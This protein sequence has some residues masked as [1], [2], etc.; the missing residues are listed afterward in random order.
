M[1]V[2]G[3]TMP[4]H[5]GTKEED[6]FIAIHDLV[7]VDYD[8]LHKYV[9]VHED[10]SPFHKNT[11]M[12]HLRALERE[13]YI[14]SFPIA[15]AN[16][17]GADRLVYTLDAKG[18]QEARELLGEVDWDTRWTQRT[19]TYIY[20]SLQVAHVLTTYKK[21]KH[22]G[23]EFLEYFSERRAFRN[24][25]EMK[26]DKD[27][28][29]RQSANT[30]IRPDGAFILK[31]VVNGKSFHFL[32]FVEMER[33]RQRIENTLEKIHR[34]NQY[35]IKRAYVNDLRFGVPIDMIRVLFI[36]QKSNERDRLMLNAKNGD[37]REIEKMHGS[38]LFATYD[39]VLENP[40]GEIW[41][42]KH[43]TNVEHLYSLTSRIE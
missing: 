14:K 18:I 16:V 29:K 37:S 28:K 43:S 26:V 2:G 42:A 12:N 24:Y 21:E 22:T 31:R 8:Y 13:G 32:Y 30:V 7:F 20:H 39:D 23:I 25:G 5:I 17:R 4:K 36:S 6:L 15:K 19:P 1:I 9:F 11:I 38:L 40:Y 33:S 27:G 3:I 34:Y 10:G 35:V 41:K